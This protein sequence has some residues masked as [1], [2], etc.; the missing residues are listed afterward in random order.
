M[1][2]LPAEVRCE[3]ETGRGGPRPDVLEAQPF[4]KWAGGKAQLL[5]QLHPFFPHA[6]SSYIEPFVGGGAVFF[7][8]KARFP[9]M[10]AALRDN[11]AELINCY[12]V[13]RD[14]VRELMLRLDEHRRQFRLQ[15]EHYYYFVRSRH[16]LDD[17]VERASRMIFLNKTC[18][19]GL[20]RVNARGEFNVPI[21]S[22]KPEKVALYDLANLT[23][24]SRALHG[25]D[26]AVQDFGQTLRETGK[27]GF[28]YV[29]PPYFPLS[30]TA[31][32]TSYT[33]E[34]FGKAEQGE[35]ARLFADAAQRDV[36]LILSNSDTPFIRELYNGFTI[37]TVKARRAVN[38]DAAKRGLISEVIVLSHPP[39]CA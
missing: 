9:K 32:F 23:A 11:N 18:Y 16:Q 3:A 17:P 19:N 8:L 24:A 37:R 27:G 12:Q 28:V 30:P 1:R 39:R 20:W 15:G 2:D 7:H 25:V 21:G 26:L 35:L 5:R 34:V 31:N 6:I 36:R 4:L 33:K 14:H 38:C 13:V 29:D 22:Y 10:R